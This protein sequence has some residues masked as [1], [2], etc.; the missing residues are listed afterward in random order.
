MISDWYC[1]RSVERERIG[2]ALDPNPSTSKPTKIRVFWFVLIG[3]RKAIGHF[4]CWVFHQTEK[5]TLPCIC[6]FLMRM[7]DD[8][9][10]N[11]R[12]RRWNCRTRSIAFRYHSI[13]VHIL[14]GIRCWSHRGWTHFGW[15]IHRRTVR[16][17]SSQWERR[18]AILKRMNPLLARSDSQWRNYI[19]SSLHT[20]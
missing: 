13:D 6:C 16:C 7:F 1:S 5:T 14:D 4:Q 11:L 20:R 19:V 15:I 3:K 17:H 2:N 8:F 12:D 10:N 18:N 9:E